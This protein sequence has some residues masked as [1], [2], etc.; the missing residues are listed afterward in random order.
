MKDLNKRVRYYQVAIDDD[1]ALDVQGNVHRRRE[2]RR[3]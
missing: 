1:T 2:S 3:V